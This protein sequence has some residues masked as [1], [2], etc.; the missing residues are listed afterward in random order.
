MG[1]TEQLTIEKAA[2]GDRTAFRTLVLEHSPALF[3]VAWRLTGDEGT[4]EDVVQDAFLKAWQKLGEFRGD[5]S[6]RS[7]MSRIT[8]N[9]AMDHLRK[10]SRRRQFETETP[11]WAPEPV[12]EG[13]PRPD[14]ELD[15][16]RQTEAAM[17]RLSDMERAALLLRHYEGHS[18]GEIAQI[19]E[20]TTGA[21]KQTIF[22]A[23][24]KMRVALAPLVTT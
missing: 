14:R 4:A 3:R 6:F 23:V 12:A 8:V 2:A 11:D 21:C 9:T 18:V 5:A 13:Q 20:L 17:R 24:R 10:R 19:L 16:R 7:W 15:I 22:R 1:E